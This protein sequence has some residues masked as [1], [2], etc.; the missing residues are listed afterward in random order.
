MCRAEAGSQPGLAGLQ[1][2]GLL[3]GLEPE[4][5]S[6]HHGFHGALQAKAK[7]SLLSAAVR[8]FL[9]LRQEVQRLQWQGMHRLLLC[10]V[11]PAAQPGPPAPAVHL[12]LHLASPRLAGACLLA[13]GVCS[14]AR[15]CSLWGCWVQVP[16]AELPQYETKSSQ[17][18]PLD[19]GLVERVLAGGELRCL[20]RC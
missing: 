9:L 4:R 7:A 1:D 11:T 17:L 19:A 5:S 20:L 2:N 15:G 16:E 8:R 10:H 18:K 3:A 14:E 13:F 6:P 12:N